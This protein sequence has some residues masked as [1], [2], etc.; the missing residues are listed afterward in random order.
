MNDE[1]INLDLSESQYIMDTYISQSVRALKEAKNIQDIIKVRWKRWYNWPFDKIDED[2]QWI[3]EGKVY[4][5][6]AYSNTWKSQ[7]SYEYVSYFL[8]INKK[9]L[10]ISTEVW[11]WDLIMYVAR[12]YYRQDLN[13]ILK[14]DFEIKQ[15]DFNNFIPYDD[16]YDYETLQ[17]VVIEHKPDIVFIDFIQCIRD[18]WNSEYERMTNL[19]ENIQKLAM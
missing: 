16:V 8:K 13:S 2:T 10:Y 12:N 9:V 1:I 4:T 7:L 11:L 17:S 5:I 15:E 14:W 18:E 6:W 19:A 3:I